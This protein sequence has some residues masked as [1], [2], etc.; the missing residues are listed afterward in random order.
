MEKLPSDFGKEGQD[1][2]SAQNMLAT[3]TLILISSSVSC[4]LHCLIFPFWLSGENVIGNGLSARVCLTRMGMAQEQIILECVQVL[5]LLLCLLIL[6][7][8]SQR[9]AEKITHE[10]ILNLILGDL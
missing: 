5:V 6:M 2:V 7:I 4:M 8:S 9:C 10:I 3:F 1:V